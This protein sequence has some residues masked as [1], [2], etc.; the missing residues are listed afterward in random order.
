MTIDSHQHFWKFDPIRDQWIAKHMQVLQTDFLPE[1]LKPILFKN[2]VDGCIAVQ[3]DQSE[4]ETEFLLDL[5][6]KHSF[7]KGVV[8]WVDLCA[9]NIEERLAHFSKNK[10]FKGV[11]HILQAEDVSF[12]SKP[13]FLH[14]ISMLEQFN[15][16]YDILV[17]STQLAAVETLVSSFPKQAF[18]VDHIAKPGIKNQQ[19]EKWATHISV[20]S[21]YE[22]VFCKISGLITEADWNHWTYEQIKPYLDHVFHVFGKDR[23]MYGS[24]W[25]VCLLAGNYKQQLQVI[26]KFTAQFSTEDK[27]LI[28]GENA[29]KFYGINT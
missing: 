25:P 3:A 4:T 1:N 23:I 2:D 7:I 15:L 29:F 24:D 22:N 5:A 27:V 10:L 28:M 26:S 6:S 8:G 16:T 17:D 13:S 19:F 18:V 11:R 21:N 12:M 20:F 14:G 9:E